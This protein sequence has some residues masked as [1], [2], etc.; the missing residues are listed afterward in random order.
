MSLHYE[1]EMSN[2]SY[3]KE[4]SPQTVYPGVLVANRYFNHNLHQKYPYTTALCL[5][6]KQKRL[7]LI[8]F[9]LKLVK[10]D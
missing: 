7:T 2:I 6:N 5:K 10:L 4:Q 9:P 8:L 3:F 1:I